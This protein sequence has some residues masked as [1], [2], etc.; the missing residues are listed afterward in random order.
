MQPSIVQDM[1]LL[2]DPVVSEI[3]VTLHT[4]LVFEVPRAAVCPGYWNQ[5]QMICLAHVTFYHVICETPLT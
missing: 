3:P 1:K 2:K 4:R 5:W